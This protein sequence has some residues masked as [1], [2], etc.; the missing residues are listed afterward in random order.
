MKKNVEESEKE[1]RYSLDTAKESR[2]SYFVNWE[3][4]SY[5]PKSNGKVSKNI[6]CKTDYKSLI[7]GTTKKK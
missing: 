2:S 5:L 7:S 3:L 1:L 6:S 4:V